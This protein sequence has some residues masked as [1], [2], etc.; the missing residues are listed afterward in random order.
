MITVSTLSCPACGGKTTRTMPI[1]AC[2][3]VAACQVCH[4]IMRPKSG[5]CCVF[6]SYSDV[7]CP[8]V[9]LGERKNSDK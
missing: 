5:D 1:D 9:Q 6:C 3:V 7:P 2:V 4:A 8:P